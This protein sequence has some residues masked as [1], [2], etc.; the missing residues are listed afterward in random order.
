MV[1]SRLSNMVYLINYC[2]LLTYNYSGSRTV[3]KLWDKK[4]SHINVTQDT[5]LK[6]SLA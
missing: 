4:H 2:I 1:I 5:S 6:I 3:M